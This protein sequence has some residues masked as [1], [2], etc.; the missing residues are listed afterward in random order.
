MC[1][2]NPFQ[3]LSQ[4]ERE[5]LEMQVLRES[6]RP[7]AVP[8]S[9]NADLG[10]PIP[11]SIASLMPPGQAVSA[12]LQDGMNIKPCLACTHSADTGGLSRKI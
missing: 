7:Q 5:N 3:F 2:C 1:L 6:L 11:M 10:Q 12:K 9:V 8:G 4:L